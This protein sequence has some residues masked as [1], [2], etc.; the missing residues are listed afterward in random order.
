MR[1]IALIPLALLVSGCWKPGPGEV[2]PTRYPWDQPIAP[3]Q[4]QPRPAA[5]PEPVTGSE[6][7]PTVAAAEPEREFIACVVPLEPVAQSGIIIR[8]NAAQPP[9]C[10]GLAPAQ[11]PPREIEGTIIADPEQA[12][13]A[14]A[15]GWDSYPAS[16]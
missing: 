15:S 6:P 16:N 3:A 14:P 10:E 13:I 5:K 8:G 7:A 12:A 9:A 11:S 2:D 4:A 1:R